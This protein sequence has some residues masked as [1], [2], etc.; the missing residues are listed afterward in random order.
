MQNLGRLLLAAIIA[1]GISG[2]LVSIVHQVA[3]VPVILDEKNPQAAHRNAPAPP[4][5]ALS[6]GGAGFRISAKV[7]IFIPPA[8][9]RPSVS[10]AGFPLGPRTCL[11]G[12]RV[13]SGVRSGEGHCGGPARK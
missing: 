8:A 5:G 6:A 3:T 2:I 12:T 13:S 4:A 11:A 9:R 10:E 1:G 7:P